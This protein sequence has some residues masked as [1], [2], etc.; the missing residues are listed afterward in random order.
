MHT[1]IHNMFILRLSK[2]AFIKNVINDYDCQDICVFQRNTGVI[3]RDLCTQVKRIPLSVT[4]EV[5]DVCS[6]K[7]SLFFL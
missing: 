6:E 4:I 2:K 3:I 1:H 7:R 5:N